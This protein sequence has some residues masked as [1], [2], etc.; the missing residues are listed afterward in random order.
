MTASVLQFATNSQAGGASSFTVAISNTTA[1][2]AF[3][4]DIFYTVTAVS[5]TGI[6]DTQGNT[7]AAIQ[8]V[9]DGTS[10]LAQ[11]RAYNIVGGASSNTIT[12]TFSGG[13][14]T[15]GL[16]VR[17]I[18]GV[19]TSSA[20]DG[21][22][23]QSQTNPGTSADAV[24]SGNASSSNQPAIVLGT[25]AHVDAA[26]TPSTGSGFTSNG[27]GTAYYASYG[28]RCESKRVTATGNQ[29]A[30]FTAGNASDDFLTAVVVMDE[31][32]TSPTA[33]RYYYGALA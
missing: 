17:E 6:S 29:A 2:S 24:T 32:T 11:W 5:V 7:Y 23:A 12:V 19:K 22:A 28:F 9:N 10:V 21:Y 33:A 8:S 4:V 26:S 20:V 3:L 13:T 27:T 31:L 15:V 16:A 1:Q 18:G 30:T 14:G 25:C